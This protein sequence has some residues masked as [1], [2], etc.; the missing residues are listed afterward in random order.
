MTSVNDLLT[1]RL[2]KNEQSTKMAQ[3]EEDNKMLRGQ[4]QNMSNVVAEINEV[5]KRL[6]LI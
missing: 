1:K 6:G 5:K 4:M 2:S 3:M